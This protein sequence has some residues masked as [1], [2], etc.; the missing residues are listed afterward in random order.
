MA[1]LVWSDTYSVGVMELDHQHKELLNLVNQIYAM[2]PNTVSKTDVFSTL[3]ALVIYAQ[4]HFDTEERYLKAY[5][6]PKLIEHQ[7]EHIAF[8][9]DVFKFAEKLEKN[10]PNIHRKI[11]DFIRN[12]YVSHILG[13]DRGYKEFLHKNGVK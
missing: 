5:N 8:T 7:K 3:N 10:D 4:T 11:V 2:D 13:T 6:F 1:Q 9:T 12:W